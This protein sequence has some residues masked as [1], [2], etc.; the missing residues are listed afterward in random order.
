MVSCKHKVPTF[1]HRLKLLRVFLNYTATVWFPS[2]PISERRQTGQP[3]HFSFA[4]ETAL[5]VSAQV[6]HVFLRHTKFQIHPDD[7]VLRLAIRLKR[8]HN[9]HPMLFHGPN[10]RASVDWISSQTV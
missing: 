6:V 4:P 5:N 9:L 2:I 3:C 7:I 1:A 10:D 8:G